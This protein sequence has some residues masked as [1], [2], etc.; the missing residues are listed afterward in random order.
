MTYGDAFPYSTPLL[1][2]ISDTFPLTDL[3]FDLDSCASGE[4]IRYYGEAENLRLDMDFFWYMAFREH[5]GQHMEEHIYKTYAVVVLKILDLT[6]GIL[7]HREHVDTPGIRLPIDFAI[8]HQFMQSTSGTESYSGGFVLVA[9]YYIKNESTAVQNGL[10]ND[11]SKSQFYQPSTRQAKP[12]LNKTITVKS[13]GLI[14]M[15]YKNQEVKEW[16]ELD[17]LS[18]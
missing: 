18:P 10:R 12:H 11:V 17:A 16:N 4:N 5:L 13:R 3:I 8:L 2:D 7:L 15:E 1:M 6:N 14:C 9:K